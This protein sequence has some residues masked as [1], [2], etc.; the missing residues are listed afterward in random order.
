MF[1]RKA[2][3]FRLLS[4]TVNDDQETHRVMDLGTDGLITDRVNEFKPAC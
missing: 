2:A 3:G 4:Y 1:I